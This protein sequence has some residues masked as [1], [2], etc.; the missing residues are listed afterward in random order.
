[1]Q[2]GCAMEGT[3]RGPLR[4]VSV[5]RFWGGQRGD[6]ARSDHNMTMVGRVLRCPITVPEGRY[7]IDVNTA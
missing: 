5:L 6:R 7:A 1:M 3:L 2:R 4:Q